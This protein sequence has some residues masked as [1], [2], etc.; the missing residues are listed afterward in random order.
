MLQRLS[1][2]LREGQFSLALFIFDN[3]ATVAATTFVFPLASER[4]WGGVPR[5]GA[6]SSVLTFTFLACRIYLDHR[7]LGSVPRRFPKEK[8]K[9]KGTYTWY[10]A[11][12]WS[13]TPK[14]LGYVTCSQG[15]SQFTCTPTSHVYPQSGMSHTCI[16]L[17]SYSRYS[18]TDPGGME[19]WVGPGGWLDS[20]TV[21]LPEGSHPLVTGLNVEQLR[22]SIPTR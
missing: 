6:I 18:F 7:R 4:F 22:W 21:Y 14:A 17:P 9:G 10:R 20:E 8:G 5:R 2:V 1:S 13:I 15:I 12:S 3:W 19:G 11:S 16:C